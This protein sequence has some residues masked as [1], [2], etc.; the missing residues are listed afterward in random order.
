MTRIRHFENNNLEINL[1]YLGESIYCP[2][3]EEYQLEVKENKYNQTTTQTTILAQCD[4]EEAI[5]TYSLNCVKKHQTRKIMFT[6]NYE[7]IYGY[8]YT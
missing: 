3:K 7:L 4:Q 2:T 6:Y 8:Y 5:Q 1:Y